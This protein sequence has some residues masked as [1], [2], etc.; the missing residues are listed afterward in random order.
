MKNCYFFAW[1]CC[2]LGFF[3]LAQ[4][5]HTSQPQQNPLM[6]SAGLCGTEMGSVA[7]V[8]FRQ[9]WKQS[10]APFES[11]LLSYEWKPQ[12]IRPNEAFLALGSQVQL[13]QT[14]DVQLVNNGF[15][16]NAAY[17]LPINRYSY[18]SGGIYVGYGQRAIEPTGQWGSQYNGLAF[19][20][21]LTPSLLLGPRYTRAYF[22]A[23][24][25]FGFQYKRGTI[26]ENTLTSLQAGLGVF[27]VNRPPFDFIASS[28]RL[29]IRSSLFIQSEFCLGQ[30]KT[31]L[32]PLVLYQFQGVSRALLYG[33]NYRYYLKGNAFS[34]LDNQRAISF[35]L[36]NRFKDAV[37]LQS[38]FAFNQFR[39]SLSADLTISSFSKVQ[40]LQSAFEVQ[41]LYLFL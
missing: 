25:G 40:R 30:T 13:D 10:L 31:A 19:D 21:S 4:D 37:I 5:L 6:I 23:G 29:P 24:F 2:F 15:S 22:D 1:Y 32:I 3:G 38:A 11:K 35:G 36:F 9:Q 28:V 12:Q 39:L 16:L 8:S 14:G 7:R 26:R 20:P 17:H 41:L 34:R 27:H 18:L 33:A